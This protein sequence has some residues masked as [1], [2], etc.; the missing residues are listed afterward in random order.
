MDLPTIEDLAELP[1]VVTEMVSSDWIDFMGHMN[2]MWYTHLFSRS[3]IEFF[4]IIGLTHDYFQANG[5][6]SFVL[7]QHIRYLA[8]VREGETVSLRIRAMGRSEKRLHFQSYL[9]KNEARVIGAT[10]EIITVHIDMSRR[11]SSLLPLQI[12]QHFDAVQKQHNALNWSAPT[13]GFTKP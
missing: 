8:E 11:R 5:A 1:L 6:G 2:V 12:A 3:I 4:K 9:I 7:E 10:S 13:N